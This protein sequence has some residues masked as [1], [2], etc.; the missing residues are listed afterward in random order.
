MAFTVS[1]SSTPPLRSTPSSTIRTLGI[2]N[3]AIHTAMQSM[4]GERRTAL[5]KGW[6]EHPLVSA[7]RLAF[8]QEAI[9]I[10]H[11]YWEN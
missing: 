6:S 7:E 11:K 2:G 4:E 5:R 3:K 1:V 10:R 8:A 9:A